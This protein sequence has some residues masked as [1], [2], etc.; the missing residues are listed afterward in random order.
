VAGNG[1][2]PPED[3]SR[4]PEVFDQHRS[5]RRARRSA[6]ALLG[7]LAQLGPDFSRSDIE[8]VIERGEVM[9]Q[10]GR[11]LLDGQRTAT[12]DSR[13]SVSRRSVPL[14]EIQLGTVALLR[15][16]K[17]RQAA[18]RLVLGAGYPETGLLLLGKDVAAVH[19]PD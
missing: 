5:V 19:G 18:D 16:L 9:V 7:G 15:T 3:L 4:Q 1:D 13:S 8:R 6:S 14:E 10:A 12:D 2:D 17:A 11:I